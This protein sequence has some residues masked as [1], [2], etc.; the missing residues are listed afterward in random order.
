MPLKL[1]CFYKVNSV[2]HTAGK[3]RQM[4]L[5]NA[6]QLSPMPKIIFHK[7]SKIYWRIVAFSYFW[8][9]SWPCSVSS[10][11][12]AGLVPGPFPRER[13]KSK[14]RDFRSLKPRPNTRRQRQ[15]TRSMPH[16]GHWGRPWPR[17]RPRGIQHWKSVHQWIATGVIVCHTTYLSSSS[18]S[19][20]R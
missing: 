1:Y 15:R 8:T 19:S 4:T 9:I 5:A 14:A 6:T 2:V 13:P 11:P 12:R 16:N 3:P 18:L 10:R 20:T 17:G 7:T